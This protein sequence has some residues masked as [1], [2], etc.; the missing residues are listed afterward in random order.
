MFTT[1][2]MRRLLPVLLLTG[3]VAAACSGGGGDAGSTT[4]APDAGFT[5][6]TSTTMSDGGSTTTSTTADTSSTTSTTTTDP[7]GVAVYSIER[8]IVGSSGDTV[9]V[10]LEP[11]TYSD[12]DL[13]NVVTDVIE[14]FAPIAQLHI[15]DDPGAVELVLLSEEQLTPEQTTVLAE[16]YFVR[17]EDGFRLV[18]EG[19][20]DTFGEVILGS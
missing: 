17:L 11:G 1:M 12:L 5:S 4:T 16:H 6:T 20:F 7:S 13:Q 10:L 15:V 2:S 18:Y 8:R 9:V 14:R 19:P 3:I